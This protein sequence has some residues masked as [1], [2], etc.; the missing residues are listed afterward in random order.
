MTKYAS[1]LPS[2]NTNG[3]AFINRMVKIAQKR[4]AELTPVVI[5]EL[6]Q[7][8]RDILS[9]HPVYTGASAGVVG[10]H[11]ADIFK[12]KSHPAYPYRNSIG[13]HFNG[14][15]SGWIITS[16]KINQYRTQHLLSNAM[17]EPYLQYVE[18]KRGFVRKAWIQ[19]LARTR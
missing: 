17:Y 6:E 1:V 9:L 15:T 10:P 16:R 7:I 14:G 4:A 5:S 13:N 3:A 8:I 2:K 12:H 18:G 19:H 11:Y